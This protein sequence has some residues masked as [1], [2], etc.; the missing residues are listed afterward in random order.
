MYLVTI[1]SEIANG[2]DFSHSEPFE[3]I[4]EFWKLFWGSRLQHRSNRS[5]IGQIQKKGSIEEDRN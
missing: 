3:A 4:P 5:N 1:C 2:F